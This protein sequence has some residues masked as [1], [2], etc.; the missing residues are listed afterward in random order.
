MLFSTQKMYYKDPFL[1]ECEAEIIEIR[2]GNEVCLNQTVAYPEGGGQISDIGVFYVDG[3]ELPF[4]DV[5]KGYGRVFSVQDFPT[6]NVDT[7]VYH[8][9]DIESADKLYVGQK[10]KMKIDLERR[11]KTTL[12]HSAIHL[13]LMIAS[14]LRGDLYHKIKGCSITT[15]HARLDFSLSERFSVEEVN[16][17]N[18]KLNALISECAPVVV[19]PYE[20]EDEAWFWQCKNYVCPCGGTHVTNTSQIGHATI[21]RKT[22]GKGSERVIVYVDNPKLTNENY[23]II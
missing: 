15:E 22:I 11:I 23:H 12:N 6:V 2:N 3:Y 18:E 9:V 8:T 20:G 14:E 21:K 1:C 13:V 19:F 10:L 16:I 7:P 4:F 17:M 5:K